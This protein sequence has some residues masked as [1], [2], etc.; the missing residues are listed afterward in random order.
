MQDGAL[1]HWSTDVRKWLNE[2]LPGRWIGRAGI[3]P[4]SLDITS[5]D[6]FLWEYIKRKVNVQNYDIFC[7]LKAAIISAFQ[8]MSD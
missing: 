5:M 3:P 8:E 6:Y 7:D 4:R 2:N 1:T